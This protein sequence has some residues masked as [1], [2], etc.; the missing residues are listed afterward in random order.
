MVAPALVLAGAPALVPVTAPDKDP[1]PLLVLSR[2]QQPHRMTRFVWRTTTRFAFTVAISVG[3]LATVSLSCAMTAR[4][5]AVAITEF[6]IA[7][8]VS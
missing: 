7:L 4:S 1:L 3:R 8:T 2:P 6:A 5:L